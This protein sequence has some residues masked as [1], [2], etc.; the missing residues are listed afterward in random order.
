MIYQYSDWQC[1][2]YDIWHLPGVGYLRGPDPRPVEPGKFVTILG[3]AHSFGRMAAVPY[4]RLLS[5]S[6]GIKAFNLSNSAAGPRYFLQSPAILDLVSQSA[7]CILQVP[8]ARS[9]GNS[10]FHNRKFGNNVFQATDGGPD[11]PLMHENQLFPPLFASGRGAEAIRLLDEMRETWV[12]EMTELLGLIT[13]PKLLFWFSSR[14]PEYRSEPHSYG[15][16]CGKFPQLVNRDML[17]RIGHAADLVVEVSTPVGLPTQFKSRFLARDAACFFA[18]HYASAQDYY[19]SQAMH[20]AA[21]AA[22]APA[23]REL[24]PAAWPAED[25]LSRH[26]G[27]IALRDQRRTIG[28]DLVCEADTKFFGALGAAIQ[29]LGIVRTAIVAGDAVA[30][31]VLLLG[32]AADWEADGFLSIRPDAEADTQNALLDEMLAPLERTNGARAIPYRLPRLSRHLPGT[33]IGDRRAT[34]LLQ[35]GANSLR[36]LGAEPL[37]ELLSTLAPNGIVIAQ[38]KAGDTGETALL[39]LLLGRIGLVPIALVQDQ[40]ILARKPAARALMEHLNRSLNPM[41]DPVFVETRLMFSGR[42]IPA[43]RARTAAESMWDHVAHPRPT[44]GFIVGKAR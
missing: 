7:A 43:L 24:V 32:L 44:R 36:H 5:E 3:T 25:S 19:P 22:L 34:G 41:I 9:C 10:R 35:L 15:S 40:L 13:V 31:A 1:Y 8:A 11:A 17:A 29:D 33:D 30:K 14:T 2:Y 18:D 4:P 12:A 16:Y 26:G 42:D 23:L 37:V 6:F 39:D 28:G 21:A 20:E 27:M 38:Y